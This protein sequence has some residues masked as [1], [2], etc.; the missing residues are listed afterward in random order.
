M[1]GVDPQVVVVVFADVVGDFVEVFGGCHGFFSFFLRI[2]WVSGWDRG[3]MCQQESQL[4]VLQVPMFFLTC[5]AVI[6][7]ST[8]SSTTPEALY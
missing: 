4:G 1:G 2:G 8:S 5:S 7:A 6:L 3:Y